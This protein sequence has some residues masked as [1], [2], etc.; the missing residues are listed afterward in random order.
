MLFA[1]EAVVQ[2]TGS[3]PGLDAQPGDQLRGLAGVGESALHDLRLQ[4]RA[5]TNPS[6]TI[7]IRLSSA[8]W[9]VRLRRARL[10]RMCR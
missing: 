4:H 5:R 10:A 2:V 6:A 1:T 8:T 7:G 9:L 3:E